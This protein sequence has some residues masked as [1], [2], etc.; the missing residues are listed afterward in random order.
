MLTNTIKQQFKKHSNIKK[1]NTEK[2]EQTETET[3]KKTQ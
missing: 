1:N 2:I 3:L